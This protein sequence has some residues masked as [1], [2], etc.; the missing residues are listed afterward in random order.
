MSRI[1][2]SVG[3]VLSEIPRDLPVFRTRR[4]AGAP[5]ASSLLRNAVRTAFFAVLFCGCV[6]TDPVEFKDEVDV[7]PFILDDPSLPNGSIIKFEKIETG[8]K[9]I[10]IDLQVRDDN[11]DQALYVR[12]RITKAD[13]SVILSKCP[14]GQLARQ[15]QPLS[16]YTLPIPT[17]SLNLGE[18]HKVEIAVSGGFTGC[19]AKNDVLQRDRFD[20][21]KDPDDIARATYWIWE[22]SNDALADPTAAK[23]LVNSCNK[24]IE[25]QSPVGTSP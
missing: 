14:D 8:P 6:V 5:L 12:T 20:W 19:Y 21:V 15:G 13:N 24:P 22:V 16:F 7:P 25:Y 11:V 1:D 4:A 3:P 2:P 18:C 9:D 23:N 10:F 17:S